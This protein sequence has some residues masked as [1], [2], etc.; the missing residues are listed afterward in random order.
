MCLDLMFTQRP[1]LWYLDGFLDSAIRTVIGNHVQTGNDYYYYTRDVGRYCTLRVNA[2][3][4]LGRGKV[5]NR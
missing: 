3:S 1:A 5:F 4:A 2:C